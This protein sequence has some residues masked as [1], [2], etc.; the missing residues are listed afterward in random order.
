MN[1]TE[2]IAP[3]TRE[4]ISVM[5][6]A[7]TDFVVFVNEIFSKSSRHFIHGEHID[8]TARFLS[9]YKKT[10][11]VSARNHF[12]SYSFYAHAMWKIMFELP[13]KSVEAHYFSY[14]QDLAGYH[15]GKL[16]QTI[17]ANP[18]FR[19]LIDKKTTAES[20]IRCTWDNKSFYTM[21]AHGLI[22]FKRGIH[23]DYVYV[24]DPFQDPENEL[25]PTI[26]TKINEIFKSNILDM[27]NEPDGELHVCGCLDPDTDILLA[28][29]NFKKLKDVMTS[30]RL[31]GYDF[32]KQKVVPQSVVACVDNGKQ[33]TARIRAGYEKESQTIIA[34]FNHPFFTPEGWKDVSGLKV[35]DYI[36]ITAKIETENNIEWLRITAIEKMGMRPTLNLT[37]E[38]KNFVANGFLTHNTPQTD[39][40][41]YFDKNVTTRFQVKILPAINEDGSALWPEWM[42]VSELEMK[43]IE[44][45][46]R[47]FKREYLCSPVY[48]TES[49]FSRDYLEKKCVDYDIVSYKARLKY[50]KQGEIIAG[51]DIGKKAHPSHLSVLEHRPDNTFVMIHQKWMD[52]WSYSNGKDFYETSPTQL[53]YLKMVITNFGIDRLYYDNTRGEFE[54][55]DEQGLLPRQM[56]PIVFNQKIKSVMATAFDKVVER[57]QIRLINEDRLLTQIC[58]VTNSLQAIQSIKGH[59]DAFFSISLALLGV[60]ELSNYTEEGTIANRRIL[61]AGVKS[62]FGDDVPIPQGF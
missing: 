4:E 14:S 42:D 37:T 45:T 54:S 30:D 50:A 55:F 20:V 22:Q 28:N 43:R 47:I 9:Q 51:F 59:G 62:I 61:K 8:N 26:I 6:R 31:L 16:K 25:N 13:Q 17:L 36:A 11:R 19:H 1:D 44:R 5:A 23:A 48:S 57:G 60:K 2:V 27:P 53:E 56:I 3:F 39:E 29:G 58:A 52:G 12:K 46:D 7:N 40:D 35:G 15:I 38:L 32:K 10:M 18:Y 24:D 33:Q 21:E 49:F 41:F 34:T